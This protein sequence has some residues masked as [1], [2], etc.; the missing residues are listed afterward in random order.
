[1]P[2][3]EEPL[4]IH[5]RSAGRVEMIHKDVE[6]SGVLHG[7]SVVLSSHPSTACAALGQPAE[8]KGRLSALHSFSRQHK[9]EDLEFLRYC[10]ECCAAPLPGAI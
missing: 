9:H 1:M 4:D 6:Q 2:P 7:A 8:R 5:A 3:I 10:P